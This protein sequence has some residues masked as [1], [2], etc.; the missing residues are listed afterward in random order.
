[1]FSLCAASI[2]APD[3]KELTAEQTQQHQAW[4]NDA[5]AELQQAL[6]A[7]WKDFAHLQKDPDL[8]ILRDLPEF[9]ALSRKPD[10]PRR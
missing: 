6:A 7:G 9:Q 5:L 2:K 10:T 4:I 8:A 3:G 1:V